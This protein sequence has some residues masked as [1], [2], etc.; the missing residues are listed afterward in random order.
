MTLILKLKL[1]R[2]KEWRGSSFWTNEV[3]GMRIAPL[4]EYLLRT[5]FLIK[6]GRG[7]ESQVWKNH[8][9][10][11]N[12][13]SVLIK[14]PSII[15]IS[16]TNQG[17]FYFTYLSLIS[18]QA[19]QPIFLKISTWLHSHLTLN[20]KLLRYFFLPYARGDKNICDLPMGLMLRKWSLQPLNLQFY[21]VCR[22]YR[23]VRKEIAAFG[24]EPSSSRE[25]K[26]VPFKGP[27]HSRWSKNILIDLGLRMF[28]NESLNFSLC[29]T[30]AMKR[31]T[32]EQ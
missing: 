19:T 4:F 20:T 9:I 1:R 28:C 29:Q 11:F 32:L 25:S 2:N 31:E 26:L 3:E 18:P 30:T 15:A 10:T 6:V 14:L 13:P 21:W 23:S 7:F 27:R 17:N 5:T 16:N 12:H 8:L 22:Q 24:F